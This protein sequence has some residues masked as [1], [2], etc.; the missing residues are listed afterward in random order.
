MTGPSRRT[1]ARGAVWSVPVVAASVAAPA[2]AASPCN[3]PEFW[4]P[5]FPS[6]GTLGNGW[7]LTEVGGTSGGG[8]DAFSGG[9]FVT[10]A[11]PRTGSRTRTVTASRDICVT[12]GRT[13]RFAWDWEAYTGNDRPM[14]SVLRV[15]GVTLPGSTVDTNNSS[16]AGSRV[17][18]WVATTTGNVTLAFVH[19]IS[20]SIWSAIG[21][22]IT[23][24]NITGSCT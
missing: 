12:Q 19:T 17:A 8:T 10:V 18:T 5:G 23:I 15:N 3:C 9:A 20:S 22:D 1:V 2:F 13:Y 14:T 16:Q 11:D 21:D 24:R 4:V 7:A 6:S